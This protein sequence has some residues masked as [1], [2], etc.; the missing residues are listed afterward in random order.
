[1][2]P[3]LEHSFVVSGQYSVENLAEARQQPALTSVPFTTEPQ[4]L[5]VMAYWR[6]VDEDWKSIR[7]TF[8][9]EQ[10]EWSA[11][12]QDMLRAMKGKVVVSA[13]A[14]HATPLPET[15]GIRV[16]LEADG[17]KKDVLSREVSAGEEINLLIPAKGRT[18]A[19]IYLDDE[20]IEEQDH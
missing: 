15:E 13:I 14:Y 2:P 19:R 10:T 1:M 8:G 17:V 16:I 7:V 20:L 18:R 6:V 4:W 11:P 5:T 12:P 3:V 9:T